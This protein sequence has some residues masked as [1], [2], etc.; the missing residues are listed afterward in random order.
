LEKPLLEGSCVNGRMV[1]N[2]HYP[3]GH[4]E[5]ILNLYEVKNKEC[6]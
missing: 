2:G 4:E 5:N 1:E 3:G 6:Y